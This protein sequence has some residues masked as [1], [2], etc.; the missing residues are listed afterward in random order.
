MGLAHTAATEGW[1]RR[2]PGLQSCTQGP[3]CHTSAQDKYAKI[4]EK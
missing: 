2:E 3:D 4:R 1:L